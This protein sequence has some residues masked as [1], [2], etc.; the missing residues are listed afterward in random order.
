MQNLHPT[1]E[2]MTSLP[3]QS[4]S[5]TDL[6]I[7]VLC[8]FYPDSPGTIV[9]IEN[10][11]EP[12]SDPS[13]IS[14]PNSLLTLYFRG[15]PPEMQQIRKFQA[16]YSN[17]C[18]RAHEATRGQD[19]FA[20]RLIALFFKQKFSRLWKTIYREG[21]KKRKRKQKQNSS[22]FL[23]KQRVLFRCLRNTR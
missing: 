21:N 19:N 22:F 17:Q 10:V 12:S 8:F 18:M 3:L 13:P 4:M 2:T 23:T 5:H 1:S 15:V 7:L 20:R 9:K 11:W 16:V 6:H 14:F